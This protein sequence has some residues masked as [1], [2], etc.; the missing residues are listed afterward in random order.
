MTP[1]ND[2]APR[3]AQGWSPVV[4][5]PARNEEER[6][7]ALLNALA[8]QTWIERKRR[9]L[10]VVLAL[11]NCSDGSASV[12]RVFEMAE[13]RLSLTI[14]EVVFA[15]PL[16]HVGSAR[17]L[18]MEIALRRLDNQER[19]VIL[20]TD[21]DAAP[22][23]DWVEA[24]LAAL[25]ADADA[26]GG[27]IIGNPDEEA[28]LGEAVQGRARRHLRYA[29]LCDRLA[30]EIDP[31]AHDP[32]PRHRDHTGASLAIRADV[33][34]QVG[35]L[36]AVAFRED[37]ALV[38]RLRAAGFRLVHPLSVRVDVSARLVGRAP[39]G[40]A[41]CLRSWIADE[42]AGRPHLVESPDA[43][44]ERLHQRRTLRLAGGE[45]AAVAIERWAQDDPDAPG[46][47]PVEAAIEAL[48]RRIA[49]LEGARDAA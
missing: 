6:L 40:M 8:R 44:L 39:G 28:Q 36:P 29:E 1:V 31:L 38:S 22:H 46:T 35:G 17:R 24:N 11:N 20:T 32:W 49:E 43:V 15:A 25:D 30:S 34:Q 42:A 26:V 10:R 12:A 16:A 3:L 41:D 45:E 2:R 48:K 19:G 7:P 14:E 33:Y 18:A 13:P 21:A 23:P 4:A 5:V 27:R 37:L 47:V 9:P